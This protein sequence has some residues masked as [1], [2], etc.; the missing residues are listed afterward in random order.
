MEYLI[1][2][3]CLLSV[4][5]ATYPPYNTPY[6]GGGMTSNYINSYHPRIYSGSFQPRYSSP[7]YV[8]MQ[9]PVYNSMSGGATGGMSLTPRTYTT[10]RI[11]VYPSSSNMG[12]NSFNS[13]GNLYNGISGTFGTA[14][15]MDGGIS[16]ISGGLPYMATGSPYMARG[17]TGGYPYTTGGMTAGYPYMNGGIGTGSSYMTGGYPTYNMGGVGGS[18]YGSTYPYST[19]MNTGLNYMQMPNYGGFNSF[20][21]RTVGF[22]PMI[23]RKKTG[24][25]Y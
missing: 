16:G 22:R 20:G 19:G 4:A 24:G 25:A 17:L 23:H 7:G 14:P 3:S 13:G 6:M 8:G 9:Y 21:G 1:L 11:T 10:T 15:Y 18:L 2:I 5:I 12:L